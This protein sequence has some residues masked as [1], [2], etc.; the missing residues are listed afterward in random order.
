MKFSIVPEI[1]NSKKIIFYDEKDIEVTICKDSIFKYIPPFQKPF[2]IIDTFAKKTTRPEEII[3]VEIDELKKMG[4]IITAIKAGRRRW[5][6]K[7]RVIY[8]IEPTSNLTPGSKKINYIPTNH[9]IKKD[10]V[11]NKIR[12]I[13]PNAG[14]PR[15][16]N[17]GPWIPFEIR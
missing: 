7:Q 5:F 15:S 17:G 9:S 3:N 11:N 6:P 14:Y 16:G 1:I 4:F 8:R 12:I 2:L 13:G 10:V